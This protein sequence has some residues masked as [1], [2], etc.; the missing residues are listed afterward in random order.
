MNVLLIGG[1]SSVINNLIIK[2]NKEGHRVYLLTGNRY[3]KLPYQK[4][5]ERY[6]FSYDSSCLNEIFESI[7]P[8]LTVFM[9][10][11]DTNFDWEKEEAEAVKYSAAVMNILMGYAM[12]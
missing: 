7:S 10:A 4:V 11:Y 6:N 9:G 5:F 8:D 2:F 12:E 1:C 3:H